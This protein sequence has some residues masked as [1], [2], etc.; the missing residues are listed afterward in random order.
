MAQTE[1][2]FLHSYDASAYEKPSVTTD[3]V[4]FSIGKGKRETYRQLPKGYRII[5]GLM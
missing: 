1:A 3:I 2:E 5:C 4:V